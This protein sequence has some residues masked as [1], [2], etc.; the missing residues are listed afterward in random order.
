LQGLRD[1]GA[2]RE[3]DEVGHGGA[4]LRESRARAQASDERGTARYS[5][6]VLERALDLVGAHCDLEQRLRDIP[7]SARA[8]GVWVRNF[9]HT[10]ER[11]GTLGRYL[12][13]CGHRASVI[14]WYPLDEVVARLA[15]AGAI[16][17]SPR[18]VKQGMRTLARDQAVLF[19]ESLLGR[20]ML[21]VLSRDPVRLLQQ[22]A[23]ARR[24]TTNYGRWEWDFSQ[25]RRAV[26]RHREEYA[27]LDSQVIGSAE[28][29]LGS[30]GVEA[31]FAL[32]M[33]DPYN[34]V[35]TITW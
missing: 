2:L 6:R 4:I 17:A 8:R 14:R 19:G 22:G 7:P 11:E 10:L 23:A 9:E 12:A 26:V 13:I 34:G 20:A 5:P 32:V 16:H 28:G 27:W 31:R 3:E 15:V 24:Q 30:I 33:S 35:M 25:P 1:L 21:R 18:D 29:T